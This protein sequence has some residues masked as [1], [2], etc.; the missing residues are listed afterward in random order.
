MIVFGELN[1][2]VKVIGTEISSTATTF[3]HTI[4][5]DFHNTKKEWLNKV[6]FIYSNSFDHSFDP[7]KCLNTWMSCLNEKG[8]C[9]IEWAWPDSD[10]YSGTARDPFGATLEE[11]RKLITKN[12]KIIDIL[13]NDKKV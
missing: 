13:Q 3:P 9:I 2:K 4:E 7:E 1:K 12:Y 5:W 11:Y 8:L 10:K 6:D